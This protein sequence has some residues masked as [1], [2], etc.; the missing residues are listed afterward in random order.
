MTQNIFQTCTFSSVVSLGKIGK[1]LGATSASLRFGVRDPCLRICCRC[2]GDSG[3]EVGRDLETGAVY[4]R[5]LN[6]SA[7]GERC[8][9]GTA[10]MGSLGGMFS[11]PTVVCGLSGSTASRWL[12]NL[13][14]VTMPTFFHDEESSI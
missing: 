3:T 4:A 5:G 11:V 12:S 8:E 10:G 9:V 13:S 2:F 14:L 7:L 1:N 6:T